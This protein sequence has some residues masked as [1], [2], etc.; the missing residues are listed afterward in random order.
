MG[1]TVLALMNHRIRRLGLCNIVLMNWFYGYQSML[2]SRKILTKMS[3]YNKKEFNYFLLKSVSV[4]Q[5]VLKHNGDA[6]LEY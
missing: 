2:F 5:N 4:C 6:L 1:Q 3:C